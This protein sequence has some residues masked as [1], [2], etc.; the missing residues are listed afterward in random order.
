MSADWVSSL[1]FVSINIVAEEDYTESVDEQSR[2][3]FNAIFLKVFVIIILT[4]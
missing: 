4:A 2:K 1:N 3:T